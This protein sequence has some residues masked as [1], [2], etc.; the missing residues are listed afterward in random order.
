MTAVLMPTEASTAAITVVGILIIGVLRRKRFA[1]RP[2]TSRQTPPPIAMIGSLRL[3]CAGSCSCCFGLGRSY[4]EGDAMQC[5]PAWCLHAPVET[6][7]V[8]LLSNFENQ[9]EALVGLRGGQG[10]NLRDNAVMRQVLQTAAAA[11]HM[12]KWQNH[13]PTNV[14]APLTN[15]QLCPR[16]PSQAEHV[17]TRRNAAP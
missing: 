11:Q 10:Q 6:E 3:H 2:Q 17:R 16:V 8:Q 4:S 13:S 15:V 7:C 1:A 14:A 9:I 5:T 12:L